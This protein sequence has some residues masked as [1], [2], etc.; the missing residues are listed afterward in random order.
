METNKDEVKCMNLK[1][2]IMIFRSDMGGNTNMKFILLTFIFITSSIFS[3]TLYQ[4]PIFEY[5]RYFTSSEIDNR[6]N[7]G[8]S[9]VDNGIRLTKFRNGRGVVLTE[10]KYLIL[11]KTEI[12]NLDDSSSI[13][14]FQDSFSPNNFYDTKVEKSELDIIREKLIKEDLEREKI[15]NI[16]VSKFKLLD[17][18]FIELKESIDILRD[19]CNEIKKFNWSTVRYDSEP[20]FI[21]RGYLLTIDFGNQYDGFSSYENYEHRPLEYTEKIA[22]IKTQINDIDR[23]VDLYKKRYEESR[24]EEG[25]GS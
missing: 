17:N 8:N 3:E 25:N 1:N 23:K 15:I 2:I 19:K 24:I 11:T 12:E 22:E 6:M 9:N 4:N 21:I 18:E 14:S 7:W 16:E 20:Y 10:D 5:T 13:I